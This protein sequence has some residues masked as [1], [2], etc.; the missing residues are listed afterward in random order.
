VKKPEIVASILGILLSIAV[1]WGTFYLPK[2]QVSLAGPELFPRVLAIFLGILSLV[3]LF[4]SLGKIAPFAKEKLENN[5]RKQKV[6][7][8]M[9]IAIAFTILYFLGMNILGFLICT[10]LYFAFLM[11]L[12]QSKKKYLKAILWSVTTTIVIYFIFGMALKASLPVG[13]IFR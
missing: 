9:F 8:K 5:S 2:F 6:F 1:Y 4:Q 13:A 3:L 12:M 11:L 10:S 7:K